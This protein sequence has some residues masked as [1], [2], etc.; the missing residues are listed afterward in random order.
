MSHIRSPNNPWSNPIRNYYG[1]M[2]MLYDNQHT[3]S[4]INNILIN[5]IQNFSLEKI[6]AF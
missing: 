6:I 5:R 4:F 2:H 1:R 3:Y